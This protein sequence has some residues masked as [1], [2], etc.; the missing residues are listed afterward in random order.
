MNGGIP[1]PAWIAGISVSLAISLHLIVRMWSR[2]PSVPPLKRF[3]WSFLVLTPF[4]GPLMYGAWFHPLPPQPKHLQGKVN[5][6][7]FIGGPGAPGR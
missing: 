6:D 4:F 7:A 5:R 1:H 3:L 2:H